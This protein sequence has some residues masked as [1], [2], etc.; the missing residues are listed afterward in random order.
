MIGYRDLVQAYK[1][2]ELD[3]HS[4]VIVHISLQSLG[5]VQGGAE[6]VIAALNSLVETLVMPAFTRRTM[7]IP[8]LG[9]S[10]NALEYDADIKSNYDAEVFDPQMAVDEDLGPAPEIF[11]KLPEVVRSQHPILSFSARNANEALNIQTRDH[12]FA[13]IQW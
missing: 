8:P 6:S 5:E 10:N 1:E 13:P 7:V 11:R 2:L 9:P 3:T 12:P 4:R